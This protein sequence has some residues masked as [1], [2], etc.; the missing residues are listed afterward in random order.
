MA[1][2]KGETMTTTTAAGETITVP[3]L[4]WDEPTGCSP[5]GWLHFAAGHPDAGHHN[6]RYC[7]DVSCCGF[8][9][10]YTDDPGRAGKPAVLA[11]CYCTR[12]TGGTYELGFMWCATVAEA[13]AFVAGNVRAYLGLPRE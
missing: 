2:H 7:G 8:Y 4:T 13:K 9:L 1:D 12:I 3:V 5:R 10:D 6:F 11:R